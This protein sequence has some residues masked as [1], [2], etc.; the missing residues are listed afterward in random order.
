MTTFYLVRVQK[1]MTSDEADTVP[2][3]SAYVAEDKLADLKMSDVAT[4]LTST[5]KDAPATNI[6]PMTE[7]EIKAWREENS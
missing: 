1:M 4:L 5:I 7:D 3:W 2:G 6:R